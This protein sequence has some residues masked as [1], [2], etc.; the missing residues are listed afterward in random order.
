MAETIQETRPP[1]PPPKPPELPRATEPRGSSGDGGAGID[2]Q[3]NAHQEAENAAR[4]EY[5]KARAGMSDGQDG[6]AQD[7]TTQDDTRGGDDSRNSLQP[8]PEFQ[9][10]LDEHSTDWDTRKAAGEHA[11]SEQPAQAETGAGQPAKALDD[12][13]STA[14]PA[15]DA[16]GQTQP[17]ST[18]LQ[19]TVEVTDP[20]AGLSD[21]GRESY[22][23]LRS[24]VDR[25]AA[26][27]PDEVRDTLSRAQLTAGAREPY[28][29]SMFVGS[30]LEN[31]VAADEEVDANPNIVHLGTAQPGQSVADFVIKD[32]N[33]DVGID[34]SGGS[35]STI[36]AH[37][38]REYIDTRSQVLD[39]PTFSQEF[40]NEVFDEPG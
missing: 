14:T 12:S 39:Y 16:V 3:A 10:Q 40:L 30:D 28:L 31:A 23:T 13:G 27:T 29:R 4:A 2:S 21:S 5:A 35:A 38:G 25:A 11:L 9:Q 15:Q 36:G 19:P 24:A 17:E 1:E 33:G 6:T 34:V 22:D 18:D 7:S 32:Q 37:L 8:T 20:V 26:R